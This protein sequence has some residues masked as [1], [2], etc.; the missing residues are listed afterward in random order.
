MNAAHQIQ[1]LEISDAELDAVA[2]GLAPEASLSADSTTL[3]SA[4]AL[5]QLGAVQGEVLGALAQ[6][7]QIGVNLTI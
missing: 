2:G 5:S 3:S 7:H 4:D 1:T 6:P